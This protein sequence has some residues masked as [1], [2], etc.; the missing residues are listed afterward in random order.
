M[1]FS[2]DGSLAIYSSTVCVNQRF[3]PNI[4][5]TANSLAEKKM[6]GFHP[7]QH[8]VKPYDPLHRRVHPRNTS[9]CFEILRGHKFLYRWKTTDRIS[10]RSI[11]ADLIPFSEISVTS[12]FGS[13]KALSSLSTSEASSRS[14]FIKVRGL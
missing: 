14:A 1:S 10:S 9:H 13:D 6:T 4:P 7:Q 12:N 8:N 2:E 3:L 11:R 5:V